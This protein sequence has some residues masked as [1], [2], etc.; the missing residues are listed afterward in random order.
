MKGNANSGIYHMPGQR[1]YS[2]TKPE[3]CFAKESAAKAAGY[4]KAKV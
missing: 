3:E 2:K 4:R 1:Y